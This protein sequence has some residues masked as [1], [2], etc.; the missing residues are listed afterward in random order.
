MKKNKASR[1]CRAAKCTIIVQWCGAKTS[2]IPSCELYIIHT[3][4]Q[5]ISEKC[6]VVES[7]AYGIKLNRNKGIPANFKI[8]EKLRF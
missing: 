5:N 1:L 8:Y 6:A 7:W 3:M 2:E 4:F